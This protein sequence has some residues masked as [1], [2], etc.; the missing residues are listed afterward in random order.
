MEAFYGTVNHDK[1]IDV[2]LPLDPPHNGKFVCKSH[3]LWLPREI[4]HF[5]Y[6]S[7]CGMA[8]V[9]DRSLC[10]KDLVRV[11][12]CCGKNTFCDR[13]SRGKDLV[14]DRSCCCKESFRDRSCRVQD[15]TLP[16]HDR[17]RKESLPQHDRSLKRV[18]TTA[19]SVGKW[20]LQQHDRS[21]DW[22]SWCGSQ[23]P[24]TLQWVR[25]T[26]KPIG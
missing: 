14:R 7:C 20:F 3:G 5:W 13:S 8:S 6:R 15:L 10:G 17:S 16:W 12:S 19:R 24:C 21:Q 4:H 9:R 26:R 23:D 11:R 18:L 1:K 25:T 2:W 22:W